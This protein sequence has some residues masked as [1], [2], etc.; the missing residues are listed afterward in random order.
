LWK[1]AAV[2]FALE[3]AEV[4]AFKRRF[5][6]DGRPVT[7]LREAG[8]RLSNLALPKR[9]QALVSVSA[10]A[11][12]AVMRIRLLLGLFFFRPHIVLISQGINWD[13]IPFARVIH[14][15]RFPYVVISQKASELYW[16][17]DWALPRVRRLYQDAAHAVFVS[18]HNR[19][20]TEL[21]LGFALRSTSIA[22]NPFLVPYDAPLDWPHSD[23]PID[24]ACVARLFPFDKGQDLLLRVLDREKWRSRSVSV[25]F[26]G[27]GPHRRGLEQAA[28]KLGLNNV[29]FAGQV[30]DVP[31]IWQRHQALVLPSRCEGLPLAVV[32]AMLAGRIVIATDAG[33]TREVVTDEVSGFLASAA[34]VDAFDD[35][36]ERAWARRD[37]WPAIAAAAA[38]H[39]RH[40]V[41]ADPGAVFVEALKPYLEAG[42]DAVFRPSRP[43]AAL[44]R[45]S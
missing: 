35:A 30:E 23:A 37:E 20:L 24:F 27:E 1:Q 11:A 38:G 5:P 18:E 41:P 26:Y 31:A 21:Q 8:C 19:E 44:Q 25:T 4:R 40:L 22:R 16:P 15:L 45:P 17:P 2:R 29:R 43:G 34:T 28:A 3:G 36:M 14:A 9:L 32:E 39:I 10:S 6:R 7:E 33:G 12:M 13:A 42:Q